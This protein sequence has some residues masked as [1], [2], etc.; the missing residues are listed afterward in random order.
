MRDVGCLLQTHESV[1]PVITV[2]VLVHGDK[3]QP[4]LGV[5][6]AV[7]A[8]PLRV[9]FPDQ[10]GVQAPMDRLVINLAV[11]KVPVQSL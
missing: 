7:E 2:L 1:Y 3:V 6:Q 4:V 5:E 10:L 8:V 9:V 11:G